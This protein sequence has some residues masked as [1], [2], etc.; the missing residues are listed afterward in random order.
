MTTPSLRFVAP[1]FAAQARVIAVLLLL[2]AYVLASPSTA[3]G[4]ESGFTSAE[5]TATHFF[6]PL[7][8]NVV[9]VAGEFA[10]GAAFQANFLQNFNQTGGIE[11]WGYPTSAVFEETPGTLSQ[12]YQRGVVDW[13]PPPGGGDLTFQ[14]R[15]AWDYLGGGLGGSIDQGVELHLTNPNPGDLIGPWGHKV[16]NVSVEGDAIGFA[17]FFHRLGGVASFGFPKTDARQDDHPQAVLHSPDRLPDSRIRQYFQAAVLEYHP[18]TPGSPVKLSLLGDTLRDSRY[19]RRAWEQYLVFGPEAPLAVGAQ[20]EL[21]LESRRGPHGSTI[22]DAAKFLELSLLRVTTDQACGSGFFVTESG[23]ALTT[24]R[25][26]VDAVTIMV[27]S[28]RGYT[29]NAHLVAGDPERDIALIKVE[30]D[31]HIP[32]LWDAF[33]GLAVG[34]ELVA[35]GYAATFSLNGRAVDCQSTPTATSLSVS[36]TDAN[37]PSYFRPTIDVGDSGGPVTMISG[38]VVGMIASGSPQRPRADF[39]TP[40][41]DAQP[42]VTSWLQDVNRGI[43][44]PRRPRFE[45]IVL[46]ERERV[47][48]PEEDAISVR[49][50]E[51]EVSTTVWLNPDSYAT[52][53]IQ[54]GNVNDNLSDRSDLILFGPLSDSG[55]VSTLR[56]IRSDGVNYSIQRHEERSEFSRGAT[57]D[58]R[59]LYNKG[60][61]ALYVNGKAVHLESGLPYEENISLKLWCLGSTYYPSIYYSN[62]RIT[63]KTLPGN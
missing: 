36:S 15:L 57:F 23:Y 43:P 22:D 14:R 59:L 28:P 60:A 21:G 1:G 58:L 50:R 63:G 62:L 34:D 35:H 41:A 52:G 44:L 56:W 29:T 8:H 12:Y 20:L 10:D 61:V 24:W 33:G 42:L 25:L 31:G 2:A 30:G 49:G 53:L 26:A 45:T 48:C 7:Q 38:R 55:G 9:D 39:F 16:A 5:I 54:F 40:A 4:A 13:Q 32:V 27:S 37:Q 46:V 18:E 11:R 3:R 17:G 47:A 19:P 6:D 51:I